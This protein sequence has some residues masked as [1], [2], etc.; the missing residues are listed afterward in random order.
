MRIIVLWPIAIRRLHGNQ[1]SKH[2]SNV[3][4]LIGPQK[5]ERRERRIRGHTR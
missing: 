2:P 5:R 4:N 1:V 3:G